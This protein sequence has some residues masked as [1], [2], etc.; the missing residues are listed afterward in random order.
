MTK[1]KWKCRDSKGIWLGDKTDWTVDLNRS[2][3]GGTTTVVPVQLGNSRTT[4]CLVVSEG[5]GDH[6]LHERALLITASPNMLDAL[7]GIAASLENVPQYVL[8]AIALAE[9]R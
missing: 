4:I 2:A 9:G 5:W 3:K 8:D 7:K 6:E 1:Q